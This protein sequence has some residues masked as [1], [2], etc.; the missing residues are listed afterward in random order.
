[1]STL[2]LSSHLR[3]GIPSGLFPSHFPTKIL[4]TPLFSTI[5]ATCS[6]HLLYFITRTVLGEQ[7]RSLSS[8]LRSFRHYP[9]TSSLLGPNIL[10]NIRF[11]NTI[12]IKAYT[13][14]FKSQVNAKQRETTPCKSEKWHKW[15]RLWTQGHNKTRCLQFAHNIPG[16]R[17]G[18]LFR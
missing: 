18:S 15:R 5:R 2:I 6:V 1:M 10:L 16:R 8:S 13:F 11:S 4:H 7:Y 3:L 17:C 14:K 12:T 9:G